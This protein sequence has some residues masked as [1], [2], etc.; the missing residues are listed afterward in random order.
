LILLDDHAVNLS[1][2]RYLAT[3]GRII[4][5]YEN[6]CWYAPRDFTVRARWPDR[7]EF[8]RNWLVLRTLSPQIRKPTAS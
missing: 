8:L 1:R 6:N 4:W 3:A 5:R 7:R 2:H